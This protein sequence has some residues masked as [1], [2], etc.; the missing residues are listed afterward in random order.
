MTNVVCSNQG[1]QFR[2]NYVQQQL[3]YPCTKYVIAALF[4]HAR[5]IKITGFLNAKCDLS[6]KDLALPGVG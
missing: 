2:T 4:Y 5:L 1:K 3:T 6:H